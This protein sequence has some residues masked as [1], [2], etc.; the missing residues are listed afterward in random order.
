MRLG[1]V[2]CVACIRAVG[3]G[4]ASGQAEEQLGDI[5]GVLV[6][7]DGSPYA[8]GPPLVELIA[9]K[10][11]NDAVDD[12]F[13]DPPASTE[14]MIDP[15]SYFAGD[16][17]DDVTTPVVPTGGE[18]IGEDDRLGALPLFL[19][20]SER[21]DPLE[22]LSAADGWGGDAYVVYDRGGTPCMNLAVRGD[23]TRDGEELLR[24][25]EAWVAA[26]PPGAAQVRS[27]GDLALV[28][29]CDPGD[30]GDPFG[31]GLGVPAAAVLL[32]QWDQGAVGAGPRRTAGV[33]EQH[34]GE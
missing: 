18:Q 33:G 27:D 24:A 31:D 4:Q 14:H 12:A 9:A 16:S 26:G 22:A 15:R 28:T 3:T 20:L 6:A 34:E 5:P 23:S 17:A 10:G 11:G 21:I 1:G 30:Q 13:E 19:L 32:R 7:M 25:F 2:P 8:L 29:A